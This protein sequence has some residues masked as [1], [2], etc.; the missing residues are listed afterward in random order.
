MTTTDELVPSASMTQNCLL[1]AGLLS[2]GDVIVSSRTGKELLCYTEPHN[3]YI[4]NS[5]TIVSIDYYLWD[6]VSKKSKR[7]KGREI[8]AM[9]EG[10]WFV[11]PCH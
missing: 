2:K 6:A 4:G 10:V 11:K 3:I 8:K 5:N 9:L 1:V 7:Y